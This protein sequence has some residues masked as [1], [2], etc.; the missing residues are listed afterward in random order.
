MTKNIKVKV[1]FDMNES[2][3]D[4]MK[5]AKPD[6]ELNKIE[7]GIRE[8]LNS[9]K[10]NEEEHKTQA[11]IAELMHQVVGAEIGVTSKNKNYFQ[12]FRNFFYRR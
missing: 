6:P 1:D 5:R 12:K 3:E 2:L 9:D 10:Y 11:E 7:D 4:I 8:Y